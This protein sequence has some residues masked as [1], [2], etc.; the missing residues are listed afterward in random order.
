MNNKFSGFLDFSEF[1]DNVHHID[2][3]ELIFREDEIAFSMK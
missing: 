2:I 1:K 3:L